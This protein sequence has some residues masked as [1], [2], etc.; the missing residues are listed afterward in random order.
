MGFLHNV[1]L[2]FAFTLQQIL[3]APFAGNLTASPDGTVLVWKVHDR[4]LR[5]LYTNAGGAIHQITNYDQDDGQDIDNVAISSDNSAVVF[6]HGGVS[7]N[8]GGDSINPL[9]LI[10]VPVRGAY[11]VPIAGGTPTLIG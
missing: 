10:P 2:I 8:S 3:S 6:L 1:V 9:S 11:I 4:G 7:D 5:N